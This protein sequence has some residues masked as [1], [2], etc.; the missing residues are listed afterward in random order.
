MT[1]TLDNLR[2]RDSVSLGEIEE[3]IEFWSAHYDSKTLL[4]VFCASDLTVCYVEA[5]H[6]RLSVASSSHKLCETIK[7]KHPPIIV[8]LRD[9]DSFVR[10]KVAETYNS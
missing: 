5:V 9:F 10:W 4:R 1:L 8:A 2:F 6:K 7:S 3:H